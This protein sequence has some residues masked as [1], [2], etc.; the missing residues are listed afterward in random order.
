MAFRQS[1]AA[2]AT[3]HNAPVGAPERGVAQSVQDRIDCTV[4]VAQPVAY[5]VQTDHV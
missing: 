4:D 1:T 5:H 3:R 2:P